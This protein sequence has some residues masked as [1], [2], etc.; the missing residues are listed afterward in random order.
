MKKHL[1]TIRKTKDKAKEPNNTRNMKY[2]REKVDT[3]IQGTFTG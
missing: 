2:C 3:D 1:K